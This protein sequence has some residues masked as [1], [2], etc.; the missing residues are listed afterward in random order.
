MQSFLQDVR[1]SLRMFW[2]SRG[3]AAAAIAAL[4]L[5]IGSNTAIFSIVNTVLLRPPNF[6]EPDRI[7][8]F[9]T[10]GPNGASQ[11]GSPAKFAHWRSLS[12]VV[13]LVSVSRESTL[14]WTGNDTPEQLRAGQVSADYFRLFGATLIMAVIARFPVLIVMGGGLL[15]F[16]AGD[17]IETDPAINSW[18]EARIPNAHLA[19]EIGCAVLTVALGYWLQQR[20][21]RKK[22]GKPV[23]LA[24]G[25][26][27][28]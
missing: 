7:V 4:A 12:D 22:H 21:R 15:G 25:T 24:N 27:K 5:G 18:L 19:F 23:D 26:D 6:P 20:D 9:E 10:A 1:H 8:V 28:E 14:N 13:E 17:V 16:I 11:G 3:F 2:Q